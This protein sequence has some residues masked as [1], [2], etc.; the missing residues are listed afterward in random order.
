MNHIATSASPLVSCDW[1][2]HHLND[3]GVRLLE[4]SA[5]PDDTTYGAGHIPGAVWW[6]WKDTLWHATDRE[7]ATPQDMAR[8]LGSLGISPQTT[9]VVYGSPVQ[10]GTY[11][12]WVL[13]MCGHQDIRLLNG[14]RKRWVGEGRTLTGELP[15]CAAVAYDAGDA[16]VSS[17]VGRQDIRA[18]LGQTGRVLLD[19]RSPEEYRGERVSPPPGFDHGAERAGRI[20]GAVHL[21]FRELLHED[22]TFLPPD[23]LRSRFAQV[24]I[25]TDTAEDVIV[26]C[27][28]S[29]R[30]T[31]VWF[32][33][34]HLLGCRNVRVYDGSWTEW[35]SIVGFPIEKS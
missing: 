12:F 24:G 26:Y 15:T 16:E 27:R 17:R 35:G 23:Q 31:L 3:P 2:A 5:A 34:R 22:D 13:T 6:Y 7:F 33:L 29:H 9:I 14:G 32:A 4:V 30:A 25:D 1:L 8:R 19:V 21:F 20:P 10:Y 11:A 28:L 18:R